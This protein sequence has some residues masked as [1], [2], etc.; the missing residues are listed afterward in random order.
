MCLLFVCLFVINAIVLTKCVFGFFLLFI[1][2]NKGTILSSPFLAVESSSSVSSISSGINSTTN[3]IQASSSLVR[4]ANGTKSNGIGGNV[5]VETIKATTATTKRVKPKAVATNKSTNHTNNH[6]RCSGGS[7]SGG[8]G[9][10]CRRGPGR[11]RKPSVVVKRSRGGGNSGQYYQL[12]Q[13]HHPTIAT[14]V[15]AGQSKQMKTQ[16]DN[17]NNS[18]LTNMMLPSPIHED[19]SYPFD[20]DSGSSTPN[21]NSL[22]TTPTTA[23][24]V[25]NSIS[26]TNMNAAA[27]VAAEDENSEG[28]VAKSSAW[29]R[30]VLGTDKAGDKST[31]SASTPTSE[32]APGNG[33]AANK[34]ML[35]PEELPY[36]PEKWSGKVCALCCLGERSQLGQGEMLRF[37]FKSGD[38]KALA[39]IAAANSS[40]SSSSSP[41]LSGNGTLHEFSTQMS[42]EEEK[43][44]RGNSNQQQ[45]QQLSNRR[46]K[47]LNKCK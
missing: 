32:K 19:G 28:D 1:C 9:S 47:G 26:S 13:C 45:Q 12:Q 2:R 7:S 43:S 30:E 5:V 11:P 27:N 39:A 23:A 41:S 18:F 33:S 8:S 14:P 46:Q 6:S 34:V 3:S 31:S 40:S 22:T 21:N 16:D 36:F 25:S 44:P 38:P 20:N 42:Q 10:S 37:E 24:N 17:T 29:I 15:A 4:A 35:P